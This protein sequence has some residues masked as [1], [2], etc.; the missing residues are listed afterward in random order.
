MDSSSA[1]DLEH[2]RTWIGREATTEDVL[3][4]RHARLMAATLGVSDD[5]V[6]EGRELPPLWHWAYFLE[7]LPAEKLGAD[8]HPARGGFLPPVPLEN[9][10]WAGGSV[11]FHAPILIGRRVH[12][13]SVV[14]AVEHKQGRSGDLVFVKIRH[15][16]SSVGV[17]S[18]SEEQDLVFKAPA[19]G[20]RHPV[21]PAEA[22]AAQRTEAVNATSTLLFRYSALTFNGHR[23]HYDV[24]YC[25]EVEGYSNLVIHGPLQATLLAGWAQRTESKPIRTFAYRGV[26]PALLGTALSLNAN[27]IGAGLELWTSLDGRNVAMSARAEF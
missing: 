7:A 14:A 5:L 6:V 26:Q 15:E 13:R 22:R 25:R 20:A 9:R 12:K 10:M 1:I 19:A 16:I 4:V 21:A 11:D 27:S 18:I 8:G 2:L 3:S 24:D 17:L 23:I